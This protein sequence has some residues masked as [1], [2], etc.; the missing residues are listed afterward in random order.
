MVGEGQPVKSIPEKR[1][2]SIAL[3]NNVPR[4]IT[5]VFVSSYPV[6]SITWSVNVQILG[7]A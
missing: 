2:F 5:L 3:F 1:I 6:H 4:K 7:Y